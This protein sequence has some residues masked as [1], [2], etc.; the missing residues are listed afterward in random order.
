MKIVTLVIIISLACGNLHAQLPVP[1]NIQKTYTQGTRSASGQPGTKYWQN[2]A[3]YRIDVQF[4][5]ATRIITGKEEIAYVNN[6]PD[7]LQRLLFKLYPNYYQ[8]GSARDSRILPADATEGVEIKQLKVNGEDKKFRIDGTNMSL[9]INRC[10]PKD[11]L[12]V[13]VQ[14][15][16]TLNK[17]SH[18][19]TG[20]VDSGSC[21]VAYFFPRIAVYDDI[22][23]WNKIA[24]TGTEEFYNDFCHFNASVTVPAQYVVWAT[25]NL[26][27]SAEVLSPVIK[28][29]LDK[30]EIS[31]DII[32]VIDSADIKAG[33]ITPAHENTWKFEADDVTDFVFATSNHYMWHSTSLVVDAATQRRTRVDVAFNP[34]HADFFEV[35]DYARQTVDA[36]SYRFPKWPF[37]YPHETIFDGLDQME[38][39]MMV[40]DNPVKDKASCIELTDHEIFHT[41]FPFYMGINETKYGWMDEGWATIGEWLISPMIDTANKDDYGIGAYSSL[42]GTESDVPIAQLSTQNDE[43]SYFLNAYAKPAMAYLYVKEMLGDSLFL[44][45]L[46]YYIQQWHG[47]HP[48]P[49]DFFNCMNT[50]S[51]KDLNWFWKRWFFDNGYADIT[52]QK[53]TQKN[54]QAT[55]TV[56]NTGGKPVPVVAT[57]TYADGSTWVVRKTIACWEKDSVTTLSFPAVKKVAKVVLGD[58]HVSDYNKADNEWVQP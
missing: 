41:M 1:L 45:G 58:L 53:L 39:P 36:M 49:F 22:D 43:T 34:I 48:M 55:I 23:G 20:E 11:T 50:G 46:H 28:Q 2:R 19:R 54:K 33:S 18:M 57:V 13:A 25:G 37:P 9:G 44:K 17:H 47:K 24:Y 14:F 3:D 7:T 27:N 12:H 35:I 32:T 26:Q 42:G 16:Y 56:K 52:L 4:N 30:A 8:Q 6:S 29:R 5:P 21:F 10:K 40:N 15:S 51:G 31:N 38:Y